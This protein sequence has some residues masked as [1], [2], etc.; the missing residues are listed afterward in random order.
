MFTLASR[1]YFASVKVMWVVLGGL[2]G[3]WVVMRDHRAYFASV[4]AI[5]VRFGD[6]DGCWVVMLA[7]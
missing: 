3:R 4:S 6:L 2:G 5:W 7:L 1:M